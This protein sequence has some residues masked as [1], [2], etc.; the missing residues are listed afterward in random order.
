MVT[1]AV[2]VEGLTEV[3]SALKR[4]AGTTRELSK[5]HRKVAKLVEGESKAQAPRGTRQQA[6]AA[7]VLLGKGTVREAT[8]AI[9]NTK[10]VPFGKGAFLGG[11]RPQFPPPW[12]GNNWN[13]LEGSGP[14]VIRD[15][16]RSRRTDILD[17]FEENV[18]DALRAAGLTVG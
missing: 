8:L 15:A 14:Y 7:Q 11:K 13:V 3:R 9:R 10:R 6:R 4:A 16:M 5:A 2:R 1:P 17:S 18:L 12:V